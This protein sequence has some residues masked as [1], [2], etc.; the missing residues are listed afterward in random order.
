MKV[1][2]GEKSLESVQLK[3]YANY[4]TLKTIYL[5]NKEHKRNSN[6]FITEHETNDDTDISIELECL[7]VSIL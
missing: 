6:V 3:K 5:E 4:Y 7:T 1:R 2:E